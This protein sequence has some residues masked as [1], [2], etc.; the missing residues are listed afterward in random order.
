MTEYSVHHGP[1]T[2]THDSDCCTYVCTYEEINTE[3]H[4]SKS[5]DVLVCNLQR[6]LLLRYGNKPEEYTSSPNL[7]ILERIPEEIRERVAREIFDEMKG[8]SATNKRPQTAQSSYGY[9]GCEVHM[10]P[11][12]RCPNDG[13]E[14]SFNWYD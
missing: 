12:G 4:T 10:K 6:T 9:Y 1:D 3:T 8:F 2:Y 14:C 13:Q 5:T 7:W 11:E